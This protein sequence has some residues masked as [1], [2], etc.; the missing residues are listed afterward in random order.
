MTKKELEGRVKDLEQQRADNRE[1][2]DRNSRTIIL[3]LKKAGFTISEKIDLCFEIYRYI[4]ISRSLL[5]K[6][7]NEKSTYIFEYPIHNGGCSFHAESLEE[8]IDKLLA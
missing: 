7:E 4:T 3:L 6:K 8:G 1:K 2:M 5:S